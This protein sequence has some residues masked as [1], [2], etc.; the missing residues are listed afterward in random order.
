MAV[1]NITYMITIDLFQTLK[2]TEHKKKYRR[3]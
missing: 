3:V 2:I 1:E